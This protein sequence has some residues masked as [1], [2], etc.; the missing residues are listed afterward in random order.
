MDLKNIKLLQAVA[1]ICRDKIKSNYSEINLS[2]FNWMY[3]EQDIGGLCVSCFMCN[4]IYFLYA[5]MIQKHIPM[6]FIGTYQ[7]HS[8]FN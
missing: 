1:E 2:I 5:L 4:Y 3:Q 7:K 6:F 8:V